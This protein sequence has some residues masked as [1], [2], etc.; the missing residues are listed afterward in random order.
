MLAPGKTLP[1]LQEHQPLPV[2][3]LLLRPLRPLRPLH[4]LRPLRP[5]PTH[6]RLKKATIEVSI[7][8]K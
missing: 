5:L 2:S 3:P 4:P 1:C 8:N 7:L 6:S